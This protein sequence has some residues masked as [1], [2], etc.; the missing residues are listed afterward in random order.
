M[1]CGDGLAWED[2]VGYVVEFVDVCLHGDWVEC[3]WYVAEAK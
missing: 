3:G 2:D 1:G